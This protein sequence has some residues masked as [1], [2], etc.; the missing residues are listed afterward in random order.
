MQQTVL[1]TGANGFVGSILAQELK[2]RGYRIR[3][4][5]RSTSNLCFIENSGIH[6]C[7][8]DLSDETCLPGA[9]EGIDFVVNVGGKSSDWGDYDSFYRANTQGVINLIEA[10]MKAKVKRF[11]QIS[12]VAVHGIGRHVDTTEEGPF[13]P[14]DFPYC[15]TKK[16]GEEKAFEYW[17]KHSFPVTAIRPGNVFGE[18]DRTTI[19]QLAEALRNRSLPYVAHGQYLTCP[20]YITNLTDAIIAAM[21]KDEAVG[22]SFLITDGLK[23][24]WKEYT[25]KLCNALGVK[26]NHFSVPAKLARLTG[27]AMEELYKLL[28]AKNPP[29]LTRYRTLQVSNHYHFSVEKARRLLG[30]SP[31]TD[32]DTAIERTIKW[33]DEFTKTGKN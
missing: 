23:I 8:G 7:I 24:T 3:G 13:Y 27:A 6:C 29:P 26:E 16:L 4:M 10:S 17:R 14:N 20:T 9:V 32:I 2:A 31:K 1:V 21:E 28:H 19:L 18:N 5:V 33:Y 22:E 15:I 11:V 12:S 30:W 25:Q